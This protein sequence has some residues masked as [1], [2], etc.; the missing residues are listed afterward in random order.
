MTDLFIKPEALKEIRTIIKNIYPKATV[1]AY[2]S[3][4]GGDAHSGSDLD[5]A[6]K[7][8][9]QEN[10]RVDDLREALRESG[11]PFLIDIFEFDRLP[12][13]FQKEIMKKYVVVY[14]GEALVEEKVARDSTSDR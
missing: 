6:V 8:F 1:W 11:V 14:D 4:V 12:L 2:G 13:S 5:L 9:G 10:A 7:S 3:R